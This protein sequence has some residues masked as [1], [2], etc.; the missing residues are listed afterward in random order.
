VSEDS[1]KNESQG[2]TRA[3]IGLGSNEGDRLGYVQ[4]AMQL[5]K[6][7]PDI[8]IVECSSLYETEPIGNEYE[9]WFVNAVAAIETSLSARDLLRVCKEIERTLARL[10]GAQSPEII[11]EGPCGTIK[12]RII[13]LDIL[14]F[15]NKRVKLPELIVPHP[16][17]TRRAYALVPLLEIAPEFVHPTLGKTVAEIHENLDAPEQVFLYGTRNPI[18]DF[19]P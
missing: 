1:H 15:G 19:E 12:T 10:A 6:D 11:H 16:Q 7:Y 5:L 9:E 8:E 3:Y 18:P 13:D 2:W 17:L 4:Q 14:F